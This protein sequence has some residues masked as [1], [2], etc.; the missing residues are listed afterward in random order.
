MA[1]QNEPGKPL[2][3]P[4]HQR[5]GSQLVD[6]LGHFRVTGDRATFYPLDGGLKTLKW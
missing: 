2:V 3:T 6:V 4:S 1:G 5:E